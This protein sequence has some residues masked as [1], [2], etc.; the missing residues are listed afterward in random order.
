MANDWIGLRRRPSY[1]E[2]SGAQCQCIEIIGHTHIDIVD[3]RLFADF[4]SFASWEEEDS[5]IRTF[6][7]VDISPFPYSVIV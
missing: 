7:M 1:Q 4:R 3:R 6:S 2:T 5:K